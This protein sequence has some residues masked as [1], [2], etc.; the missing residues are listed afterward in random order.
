MKTF[1]RASGE[2]DVM[3]A[4]LHPT[5]KAASADVARSIESMVFTFVSVYLKTITSRF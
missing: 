3:V 1:S 4:A 2:L 5:F